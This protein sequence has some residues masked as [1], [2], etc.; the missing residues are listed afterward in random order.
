MDSYLSKTVKIQ[1]SEK[2][3]VVATLYFGQAFILCRPINK[4]VGWFLRIIS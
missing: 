3:A 2:V 1:A 4:I